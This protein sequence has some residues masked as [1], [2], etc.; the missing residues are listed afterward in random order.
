MP[1][2]ASLSGLTRYIERTDWSDALTEVLAEHI[3]PACETF[4]VDRADLDR[5][6]GES[7]S[8]VLWGC[9]FEDFL[10][11]ISPDGRNV[12]DDYLKRRGYAEG[13]GAKRYMKAL[14]GAV[15]SLY[16]VSDI[17]PGKS[18]LA[19]DLIRGGEPVRI[20]EKRGSE[21][22][23]NWD[24]IAARVVGLGSDWQMAGGALL[25]SRDL[26]ERALASFREVI[27]RM[28]EDLRDLVK[29]GGDRAADGPLNE[30]GIETLVLANAAPT[31]TTMWLS[32]ALDAALNPQ[33]PKLENADGDPVVICASTFTL[34][35][36]VKPAECRAALAAIPDLRKNSAKLF[37]WLAPL[38]EGAG[39]EPAARSEGV[40]VL[41][42]ETSDGYA[43]LGGVE[44]K[45][46]Q[47]EL[48]TNSRERAARGEA[49][50]GA[51]LGDLAIKIEREET[52]AEDVLAEKRA[53]QARGS[54]RQ[55]AMPTGIPA[56][57]ARAIMHSYLDRHYRQVIEQPLP[58][59][60]G[61]SPREAARSMAG[62]TK[63]VAWLKTLENHAARSVETADVTAGYDFGWIW[64]ELG[65]TELRV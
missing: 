54:K 39:I 1:N 10:T 34:R 3:E 29:Q 4:G 36:G 12:V 25:F 2:A 17:V 41:T 30:T 60:G 43:L 14:R 16:E 33:S 22:M 7:C 13:G 5:L 15:M 21:C 52:S 65:V 38:A 55:K 47:V 11:R 50:I 8:Q 32:N 46:N 58:V 45:K 64:R 51:A 6:L 24:R 57:E 56:D 23:K 48:S 40:I 42:S 59:L 31:L 9:A 35:A 19:R 26:S 49:L 28:P 63:V 61:V 37:D 20:T 18:F 53:S 44:I 62:R 27:D